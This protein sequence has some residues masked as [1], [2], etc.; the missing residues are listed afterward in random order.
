M[1]NFYSSSTAVYGTIS[2]SSRPLLSADGNT[3][4]SDKEKIFER[5][6]EHFDS[7]L[8]RSS[9]INEKTIER[10]PQISSNNSLAEPPTV[11]EVTK[12]IK[13]L[14]SGEVLGTDPAEVYATGGQKLDE[15]LTSLLTTMCIQE[16]LPTYLPTWIQEELKD[17]SIIHFYKRKGNRNCCNSH[18][19]I[20]L[21]SIAGKILASVL[22]NRLI[23]HL[24][25]DLLPESQCG[26]RAGRSTA[27]MIFAAR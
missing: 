21:L 15:R 19:G 27:D 18:L 17:A 2:S 13:R 25:C 10:L 22:L 3:L 8:N 23:A 12:A 7:V 20:S 1:K 14:F 16:K 24:E 26:F 9:T 11:D 4:M 6:T 5:W